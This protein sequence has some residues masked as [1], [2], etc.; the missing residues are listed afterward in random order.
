LIRGRDLP[1][2]S[3]WAFLKWIWAFPKKKKPMIFEKLEK[4]RRHKQVLILGT[5]AETQ[6]V[7]GQIV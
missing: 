7:L 6:P 5:R 4:I 2:T 3:G 1:G